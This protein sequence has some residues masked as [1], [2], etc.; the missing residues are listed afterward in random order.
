[1]RKKYRIEITKTAKQDV[2]SAHEIIARDKPKA[3]AKWV[4]VFDRHVRSLR[5][6]PMRYEVIPEVDEIQVP[7]RHII[8]G[9]YRILYKIEEDL[10]TI[11]RVI[12]AAR[13]LRSRHLEE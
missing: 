1:M 8:W 13:L 5:Y 2:A 7:Y 12:N 11:V 3:A 9:N 10:V 6:L 4:R